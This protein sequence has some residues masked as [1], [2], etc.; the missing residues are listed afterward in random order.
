VAL[1][2]YKYYIVVTVDFS[3]SFD[4]TQPWQACTMEYWEYSTANNLAKCDDGSGQ[5]GRPPASLAGF[6]W[7]ISICKFEGDS[8]S[9]DDVFNKDVVAASAECKEGTSKLVDT[10]RQYE[11]F[12]LWQIF[13]ENGYCPSSSKEALVH[14]SAK[15][16]KVTSSP[17][18]NGQPTGFTT[19][20]ASGDRPPVKD[21][22]PFWTAPGHHRTSRAAPKR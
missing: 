19:D 3:F 8:Q 22:P 20:H 10:I 11:D 4:T 5:K 2:T 17:P 15:N 13:R 18:A 1:P 16:G 9:R 6:W 21:P 14:I 7:E 12:E